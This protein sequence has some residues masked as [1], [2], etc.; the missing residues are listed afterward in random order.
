M[1]TTRYVPTHLSTGADGETLPLDHIK[2]KNVVGFCGI[3]DPTFF[4][5]TLTHLGAHVVRMRRFPDHYRY[6]SADLASINK[7]AG[8]NNADA[9]VTTQKD[10]VRL[11][12]DISTACPL[13]AVAVEIKTDD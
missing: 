10:M 8:E 6:T 4:E 1:S 7:D 11:P 3:A 5:R 13:Y 2:G 9:I 12:D